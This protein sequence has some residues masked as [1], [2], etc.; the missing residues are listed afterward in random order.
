MSA[1]LDDAVSRDRRGAGSALRRTCPECGPDRQSRNKK[2]RTLSVTFGDDHALYLCHH[3]EAKGRVNFEDTSL[4]EFKEQP[5]TSVELDDELTDQSNV[6]S[7]DVHKLSHVEMD[8]M[9]DK[10]V[11]WL[12]SRGISKETADKCGLGSGSM[13]I[14]AHG[15]ERPCVG[16]PYTHLDGSFAI[17]WRTGGKKFTQTGSASELW[18]IQEFSGGDLIICEGE[19][20]AL[21]YQEAGIFAVSVPNGAPSRASTGTASKKYEYLFAA[22]D[23]I[24]RADR[25]LIATDQDEPGRILAEEIVRRLGRGKCWVV[26]YPDDCKDPN[27]VLMTHGPEALASTAVQATPWPVKGIRDAKEFRAGALSL[28]HNGMDRGISVGIENLDSLY[29][30]NPQTLTVITGIPGS[31]KSSFLTWLSVNLASRHGWGSV[32]MSAE[33]PTEIHVLQMAAAYMSKPFHGPYKMDEEELLVA[34]DWVEQ[35]FA[36]L[37]ESDTSIQSVLDRAAISIMRT[38]ARILQVDPYNFLTTG[39]SAEEGVLQ[40]NKLLVGLKSFAVEHDC[41]VWLV[42]HPTKMYRGQDGT[43]PTPGGYDISGSAAFFNVP[44]AGI[45]LSR[46]E[47]GEAKVT[48][49]KARFPWI[50]ALGNTDLD[51]NSHSGVFSAPLFG[52]SIAQKASF[53]ETSEEN[54]DD[55]DL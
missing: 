4:T 8:P 29:R 20:D 14:R 1:L 32:I 54:F 28:Y 9:S 44:D 13:W 50:G 33:T 22:R 6:V 10:Q 45:S 30:A 18:R 35:N 38:G 24:K 55:F 41:A 36:F 19:M 17:K 5:T 43:T 53:K 16:F 34:L 23:Q 21:A 25:V 39:D 3:C 31:G 52:A 51:F 48:C 26:N 40:I 7:I 11:D 15:E 47:L 37:D 42:A 46:G 12:S 27:D 49:W 2:E